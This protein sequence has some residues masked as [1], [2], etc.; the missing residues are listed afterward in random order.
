MFGLCNY[1]FVNWDCKLYANINFQPQNCFRLLFDENCRYF[2]LVMLQ[3][4]ETKEKRT[5]LWKAFV[6]D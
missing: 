3:V 5:W 4:P 2:L 1:V 6:L